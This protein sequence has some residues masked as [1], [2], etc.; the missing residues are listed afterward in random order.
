MFYRL[1]EMVNELNSTNSKNEKMEI[2]DRY[3]DL[4]NVLEYTY[5]PYKKYGVK[6]SQLKKKSDIVSGWDQYEKLVIHEIER[7]NSRLEKLD[8]RLA[9]IEQRLAVLHTKMYVA[10]FAASCILTAGLN[11]IFAALYKS[12]S[13]RG[14]NLIGDLNDR[15]NKRLRDSSFRSST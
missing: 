7:N 2:L 4:M 12:D 15:T 6:S 9:S 10:A 3:P 1:S 5:N 11:F 13:R 8:Q 14:N